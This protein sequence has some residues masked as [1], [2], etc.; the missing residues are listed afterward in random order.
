VAE[1]AEDAK[2]KG[3][4]IYT[5]YVVVGSITDFVSERLVETGSV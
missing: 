4:K 3:Q 5:V 2:S 1:H